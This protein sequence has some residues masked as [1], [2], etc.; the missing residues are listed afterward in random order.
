MCAFGQCFLKYKTNSESISFIRE[1]VF[2]I[3]YEIH[4][5]NIQVHINNFIPWR[6]ELAGLAQ[7]VCP[8]TYVTNVGIFEYK[9]NSRWFE[10]N[11]GLKVD[12]R[13]FLLFVCDVCFQEMPNL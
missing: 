3:T 8:N 1:V 9:L 2:T 10:A 7:E 5:I 4:C 11:R 12:A 6:C 13:S